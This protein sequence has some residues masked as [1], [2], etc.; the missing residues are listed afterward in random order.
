MNNEV[1]VGYLPQCDFCSE[2]AIYDAKTKMGPWAYMCEK[3]F[4]IN[5]GKLGN[6]KGQ[7][8]IVI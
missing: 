3:H 1:E 8:L 2:K 7:K 6:G 4:K 5:L